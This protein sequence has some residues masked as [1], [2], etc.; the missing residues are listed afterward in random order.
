LSTIDTSPIASNIADIIADVAYSP[1]IFLIN[2][3]SI[4]IAYYLDKSLLDLTNVFINLAASSLSFR[5]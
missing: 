2:I 1:S 3:F 5:S 4:G